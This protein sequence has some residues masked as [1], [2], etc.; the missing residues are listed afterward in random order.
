MQA[1]VVFLLPACA[2]RLSWHQDWPSSTDEGIFP[3]TK[4]QNL[5]LRD[6]LKDNFAMKREHNFIPREKVF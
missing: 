2:G 5:T 3:R 4:L 6:N 1:D